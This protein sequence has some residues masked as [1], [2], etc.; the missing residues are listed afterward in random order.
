MVSGSLI[1]KVYANFVG[2]DFSDP[3]VASYRSPDALN[4][5]K[6]YE[7]SGN[8]IETR[9]GME[10]VEDFDNSIFG[11]FFYKKNDVDMMIVHCGTKLYKIVN[12]ERTILYE[13]MK[14]AR[15]QSF[16]FNNV[17]YIKDG[18]NYLRYDGEII[19]DVVGYIPA[20]SIGRKPAGGGSIYEDIN[21]LSPWR[22]NSFLADGE[23][24]DYYLDAT[25]IDGECPIIIVNDELLEYPTD[26]EYDTTQG[27]IIF[28][29]APQPPLTDGQDNVFITFKKTVSGYADRI[30]RCNLLAV[31]DNRVFFSGN[32]NYP[33][34]IWHTSLEDPSY[35]SD[36]DYY[37]EGLDMSPVK[38]MIPGNNA[39]WVLKEPS[40]ANTTV[41]Y[42]NPVVDAEYG[43][44]YPSSHSS[45]SIGCIAT[46]INF[47]DDIVFF[48]DRGMEAINGD[49]TSE[50]VLAHRSTLIDS[51]I[52]AEEKYREMILEEWK[53]YLLVIIDNKI[54]LAN[55]NSMFQK[56]NHYE[57]EWFFWTLEKNIICTKVKD[58]I[59]YL[60]TEDGIY[61]LTDNSEEREIE[62][63]WLTAEDEFGYPQYQKTTNKRGCV[64]D[65]EG[66]DLKV[67]ARTD[68]NDYEDID[69]EYTKRY[70]VCRIKMKKWKAI[71]LKIE[72]TKPFKFYSGT[73]EAYIG[74]YIKR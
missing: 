15:S 40:Q 57:Y 30:K 45:I 46:G 12:G 10:K 61:K 17:L 39:L 13:G 33:N 16:I 51:K 37:N 31:F 4:V 53:G 62:S 22:K 3:E 54:Y 48:S 50:Q 41:F 23:S 42:H 59:L 9:P 44:I 69:F 58:G 56:E 68:D 47:N 11:L 21:M 26:Y 7:E 73:L 25:N 52:L 8:C 64:L 36:L 63:Y 35:C 38:A 71:Q 32:P 67:S 6:N 55:S 34:T 18:I 60:G 24:K 74:G 66:K 19:G 29:E 65:L 49:I 72:S 20:T 14:P 28:T 1:S 2:V 70:V 43:K 27:K 5:W